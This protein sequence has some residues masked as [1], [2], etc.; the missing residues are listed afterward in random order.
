[1]QRTLD[2][3]LNWITFGTSTNRGNSEFDMAARDAS[4]E[5]PDIVLCGL[6]LDL[7]VDLSRADLLC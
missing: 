1:M 5:H 3:D 6:K 4:S 2:L 7:L